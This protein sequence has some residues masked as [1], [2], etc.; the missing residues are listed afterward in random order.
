MLGL[1]VVSPKAQR[2]AV[3]QTLQHLRH[4]QLLLQI[5]A[6]VVRIEFD[7]VHLNRVDLVAGDFV[8]AIVELRGGILELERT[9]VMFR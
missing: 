1:V 2:F 7:D 9:Q 8:G 4:E 5:V 6:V 3:L